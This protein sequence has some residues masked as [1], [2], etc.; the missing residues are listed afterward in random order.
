MLA[1]R[2]CVKC[3]GNRTGNTARSDNGKMNQL[4]Q[5]PNYW[6]L[7]CVPCSYTVAS[8][9]FILKRRLS[10][11][12][13]SVSPVYELASNLQQLQQKRTL[14]VTKLSPSFLNEAPAMADEKEIVGSSAVG[15]IIKKG[16]GKAPLGVKGLFSESFAPIYHCVSAGEASLDSNTWCF[17]H[18]F[19][20]SS[21]SS[22]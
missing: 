2:A 1:K 12:L 10:F 5:N 14:F 7:N 22:A 4:I 19:K 15:L 17:L 13:P 18:Y 21:G 9:R 8:S 20:V 11:F 6:L 16:A 3:G